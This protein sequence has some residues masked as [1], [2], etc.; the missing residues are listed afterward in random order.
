MCVLVI[1]PGGY[2]SITSWRP[3]TAEI[4]SELLRPFPKQARSGATF[5]VLKAKELAGPP[6]SSLHLVEDQQ[7]LVRITPLPESLDVFLGTEARSPSLVSLQQN[8]CNVSRLD[9]ET[10]QRCLKDLKPKILGAKTVRIGHLHKARVVIND[11][12]L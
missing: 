5:V 8:S 9:V 4:G 1:A 2:R 11:P 10:F 7:G 6:E 3:R 12:L